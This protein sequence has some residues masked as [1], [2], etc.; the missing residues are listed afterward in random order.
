MWAIWHT[1]T[2]NRCQ[3][4]TCPNRLVYLESRRADGM[5]VL[6]NFTETA[7]QRTIAAPYACLSYC[8]GA[9][10]DGVVTTKKAN[11]QEH[12]AGIMISTLP[13]T[14]QDA[15]TICLRL[16]IRYLWVDAL[17]IIQDDAEDW[18]AE[19]ARMGDIFSRSHITLAAHR[20][21]SCKQDFLGEHRLA[22]PDFHLEFST[23]STVPSGMRH[24]SRTG[25]TRNPRPCQGL[26]G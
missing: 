2:A 18:K 1:A 17:C 12:Q 5:A 11:L 15:A 3:R 14:V 26:P 16:G 23:N 25:W 9:D 10:L 24:P 6:V 21:S 8:L 19:S 4:S 13:K 7:T 20:A 22:R